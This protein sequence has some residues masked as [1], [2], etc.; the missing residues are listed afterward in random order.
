M[1]KK[2]RESRVLMKSRAKLWY[3]IRQVTPGFGIR[4]LR[5][6]K[7]TSRVSKVRLKEDAV[8]YVKNPILRENK[9]CVND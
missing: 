4:V 9:C 8:G 3:L 6:S 5:V 7:E 2:S 1:I